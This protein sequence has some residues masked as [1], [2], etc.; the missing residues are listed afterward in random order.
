LDGARV[1][2]VQRDVRVAL[3]AGYGV[4]GDRAGHGVYTLQGVGSNG[5]W[6]GVIS[7]ALLAPG[8]GSLHPGLYSISKKAAGHSPLTTIPYSLKSQSVSPGSNPASGRRG[9]RSARTRWCRP[10]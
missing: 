10:T 3:D 4:D 8:C 7:P 2:E 6:W 9:V 5:E 1:V